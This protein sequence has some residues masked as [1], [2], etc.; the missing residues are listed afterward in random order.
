[1]SATRSLLVLAL[2]SAPV[3][4]GVAVSARADLEVTLRNGDRV[5]GTIF[6]A[7]EQETFAIELPQGARLNATASP[8]KTASRR[9]RGG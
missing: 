8:K 1:M 7:S 4:V 5:R 9:S 2:A 6:P 3:L